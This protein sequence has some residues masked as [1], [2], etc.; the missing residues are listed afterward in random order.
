MEDGYFTPMETSLSYLH[1]SH[2]NLWEVSRNVFGNLY[3]LIWLDLGH[4]R[5]SEMRF[6]AFRG[7]KKLQVFIASHNRLV[8][9]PSDLFKGLTELRL[10]DFS[11]NKLRVLPDVFFNEESLEAL[12][13]AHNE[14]SRVPV[15]SFSTQSASVLY[16]LDVSYNSITALPIFEML[17]RF[18]VRNYVFQ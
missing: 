14:L 17:S 16:D 11:N 13:M 1:M 6:D 2:N 3:N 8:D 18:K 7:S 10:V 9:V 12:N 4:N 5:I 15:L